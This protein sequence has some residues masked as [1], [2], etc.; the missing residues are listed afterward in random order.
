MKGSR[1][2]PWSLL[3]L[4]GFAGCDDDS[5]SPADVAASADDTGASDLRA[6]QSIEVDSQVPDL[7][8]DAPVVPRL[9]PHACLIDPACSQVMVAAHRG[10][11]LELP[12][13]SI[14]A[15][16]AA[17]EIGADFVEV[18]V[19]HTSDEVL[20]LMHNGSV[21]ATTNGTGQVDELTW[22]EISELFL[23]AG[24]PEIAETMDVPLFEEA[25]T[26]AQELGI[27][28]Y[29]DEK[30][31]RFDLVAQV[32]QDGDFYDVALIRDGLDTIVQ[33]A[34][35]D[36]ELLLM[37]AIEDAAMLDSALEMLPDLRIVELSQTTV[38]PEFCSHAREVGVKVQQDVMVLG[39]AVALLAHDYTGWKAFIEAG[40]S[41][42]QTDLPHILVPLIV[43]YDRTGF[44]PDAGPGGD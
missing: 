10:F 17:A 41:L 35:L 12:Q 37:P 27:M 24:D 7:L 15:L 9:G 13:N 40:V 23:T 44:F 32:I 28:L 16:R 29:V 33:L 14:A 21:D 26:L 6:D 22:A 2:A 18:D 4:L 31:A 38:R 8:P 42:V 34:A 36:S 39:D 3:L 20:I 19:R 5:P 1:F 43:E 11:H 25:L 30:T